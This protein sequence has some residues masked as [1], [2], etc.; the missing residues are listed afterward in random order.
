MATD[1][2]IYPYIYTY[3]KVQGEQLFLAISKLSEKMWSQNSQEQSTEGLAM[4]GQLRPT[5][6]NA[7]SFQS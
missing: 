1:I 7:G 5:G 2:F 3:L 6:L 4:Q